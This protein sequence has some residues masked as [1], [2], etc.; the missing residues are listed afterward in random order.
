MLSTSQLYEGVAEEYR[1]EA[2]QKWGQ[3]A[4]KH[5]EKHL[6]KLTKADFDHLKNDFNALNTTLA[7]VVSL[8]PG[9]ARVQQ[10][11]AQHY[12]Y[13]AQFWGKKPSP[14]AYAGLGELYVSDERYTTQNGLPNPE[15]AQFMKEAMSIFAQSLPPNSPHSS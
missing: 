9:H 15:F 12:G 8:A 5:S 11:L 14:E 2:T 7:E 4:V 10:L 3:E 6:K 1:H 13:I